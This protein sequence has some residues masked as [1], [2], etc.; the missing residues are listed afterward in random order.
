MLPRYAAWSRTLR[1]CATAAVLVVLA[2]P[3]SLAAQGVTTAAISG[4][5]TDTSGLPLENAIVTAVHEPTG[6]SYRGT[7]RAGGA[8]TI[9]NMRVGGP[10]RLTATL[11]GYQPGT[12]AGVQ[13]VLA[14][15]QRV[16]FALVAQAV[17]VAGIEV[18]AE[19]DP[20]LNAGRTG[21][22][23]FIGED[24]V[25]MMPSVKRSTRDLTR[26][27]PRSDGNYAFGGRNWLFNNITVDGSYFNNSFGLDDPAPGGQANAEPLPFDA[28]E[29]V[30]VAVAP[31]DVRQ[32]GFTGANVNIVTRSGTNDLRLN[33]YT[34][35]RNDALQGNSV[36]GQ[37]V[38]A[39]PSLSFIQ[40]GF[41]VG[42]PLLRDRLFIFLNAEV[43]RRDDPGSDYVACTTACTGTLPLGVSRVRASTMD[44][45]R[46]RMISEYN[47]DPG[48]YQDYTHQTDNNKFLLRL[49]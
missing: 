29:Q 6:T 31:F 33:A 13:L 37:Q 10:Y 39:N 3:S 20:V 22:A 46:Q 14:Q 18:A 21:A 34:F 35:F 40:S 45:I 38:A 42:G 49:D 47:Y 11:V 15:T 4:I 25:A 30:A 27:D 7:A 23:T 12:R 16:D 26:L 9:L 24:A 43:E 17:Q 1:A 2:V 44:S 36:E 19:R 5:V 28:I 32:S 48:P 41:S 8:Y